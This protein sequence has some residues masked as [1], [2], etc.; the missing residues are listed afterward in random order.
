MMKHGLR[1]SAG[2][3]PAGYKRHPIFCA[4]LRILAIGAAWPR[5]KNPRKLP[6]NCGEKDL[7]GSIGRKL[8]SVAAIFSKLGL[9]RPIIHRLG[10][11]ERRMQRMWLT[12]RNGRF[13]GKV[14]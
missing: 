12:Y 11:A 14:S 5:Q 13:V 2:P 7:I 10:K 4:G 6:C 3:G 9:F 8:N 1:L